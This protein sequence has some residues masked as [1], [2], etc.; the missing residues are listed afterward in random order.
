MLLNDERLVKSG[1]A[2]GEDGEDE[3]PQPLI[4]ALVYN[5]KP[6]PPNNSSS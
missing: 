4:I 3:S 5:N 2:S 1:D 6:A